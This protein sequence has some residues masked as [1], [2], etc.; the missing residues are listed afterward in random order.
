MKSVCY[1]AASLLAA[2]FFLAGPASAQMQGPSDAGADSS[3]GSG[4][5]AGFEDGLC[6]AMQDTGSKVQEGA[7]DNDREM[8]GHM[9]RMRKMMEHMEGMRK[10]AGRGGTGPRVVLLRGNAKIV[11]QC[12]ARDSTTDCV[13]AAIVLLNHAAEKDETARAK[14]PQQPQ[15][16][17]TPAPAPTPPAGMPQGPQPH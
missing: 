11:L 6:A 5:D 17:P 12:A 1:A 14:P 7:G 16:V 10:M 13:N 3:H 2:S 4:Y 15:A 9:A 8:N